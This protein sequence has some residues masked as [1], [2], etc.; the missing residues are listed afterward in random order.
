MT[1]WGGNR[2][3][4]RGRPVKTFLSYLFSYYRDEGSNAWLCNLPPPFWHPSC[5]GHNGDSEAI[6]LEVYYNFGTRHWVLDNARYSQHGSYPTYVR[7]PSS[8]TYPT[9]LE[10]PGRLGGYPRAY[11]SQGKHANYPTTSACN[12]G[13]AFNTD[14]CVSVDTT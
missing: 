8:A 10:Y 6:F 11:V 5:E 2:T 9:Q 1:M 4:L 3:G 7:V 13:G 12:S 14:T